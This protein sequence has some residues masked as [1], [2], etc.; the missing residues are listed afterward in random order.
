MTL[1]GRRQ[2]LRLAAGAAALPAVSRVA[3]AQSYPS[4]PVRIIVPYAPGAGA[5]I[6]ARV[7]VVHRRGKF[8]AAPQSAA[9]LQHLADEGRIDLVV[10][11]QLHALEGEQGQLS[12]LQIFFGSEVAVSF[13]AGAIQHQHRD[14]N[15]GDVRSTPRYPIPA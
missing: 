7:S 15:G 10:P 9:K 14:S 8:R 6:A 12:Y 11:Y 13:S 5:D 4:R 1:P 2:V 3:G